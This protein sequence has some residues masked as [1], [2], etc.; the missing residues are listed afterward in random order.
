MKHPILFA[1]NP[2]DWSEKSNIK[3]QLNYPNYV[4][5]FLSDIYEGEVSEVRLN[6]SFNNSKV[7]SYKYADTANQDKN[8]FEVLLETGKGNYI[9]PG[10]RITY[11]FDITSGGKTYTSKP[12]QFYYLDPSVTWKSTTSKHLTLI[13]HDRSEKEINSIVKKVIESNLQLTELLELPNPLPITGV[14]LNS[15]REAEK[16]F[17]K[18]S[19]AALEEDLYGRFA[20]SH[21]N[22]FII[23]VAAPNGIVH[24]STHLIVNQSLK[25]PVTRLPAWL[26]EGLAMYFE[27]KQHLWRADRKILQDYV[28]GHWFDIR[29]MQ[30]VPGKPSDVR[31]FYSISESFVDF[32]FSEYGSRKIKDLLNN[33]D[34]G[35]SVDEAMLSTYGTPLETIQSNWINALSNRFEK[36]INI[37]I[38][39]FG[40]SLILTSVFLIALSV[41]VV[42]WLKY[43]LSDHNPE[44]HLREDEYEE[45]YWD[46]K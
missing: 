14:I 43:K 27:E 20:F 38:G 21:Y 4:I 7:W 12:N 13:W 8:R 24:E 28:S 18:I 36:K 15:R 34:S 33:L 42:G 10:T 22:T 5:F 17:P 30:T 41:S 46:K 45:G 19:E 40:T 9:P 3:H 11:F 1:S 2:D 31:L 44:D 37:D 23:T 39:S 25:S 35:K 29:N 32:L 16:A 26:N 6:Y